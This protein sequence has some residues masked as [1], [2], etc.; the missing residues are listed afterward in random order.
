[1][2]KWNEN[3]QL[4]SLLGLVENFLFFN[5]RKG[6]SRIFSLRECAS[7]KY[8]TLQWISLIFAC[9][10]LEYFWNVDYTWKLLPSMYQ[11]P[12][13][14]SQ[15]KI[16]ACKR[17]SELVSLRMLFSVR[18]IR[19]ILNPLSNLFYNTKNRKLPREKFLQKF[20]RFVGI[21]ENDVKRQRSILSLEYRK[22][23]SVAI[24]SIFHCSGDRKKIE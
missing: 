24:F 20:R 15:R 21:C 4:W 12:T 10:F 2:I 3:V 6:I 8:V 14:K 17:R 1:M 23:Y 7:K 18:E 5:S 19:L 11:V 22:K 16:Q 9:F 13:T